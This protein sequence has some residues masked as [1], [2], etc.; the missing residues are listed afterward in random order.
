V[1]FPS[2][3]RPIPRTP[4][5][6]TP[7]IPVGKRVFV[8]CPDNRSGFV[9]LTDE[10]GKVP[11]A[12]HL[13][14]GVEVEVIAWRPRVAGAAHYRVRV[15][16]DGADGWL[17]VA[18]LRSALVPLPVPDSPA[19][20]PTP[21]THAVGKPF[22]PRHRAAVPRAVTTAPRTSV[23]AGG[24][25]FGQHFEAESPSAPPAP[26]SPEPAGDGARRRFGQ[27]S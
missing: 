8:H 3:S 20:Q 5:R 2:R 26:T 18:N 22:E 1:L 23:P 15:P 14:D 6:S 21:P 19:P 24:R 11:S 25:R 4:S 9:T 16:P 10:G 17:P 13:A 12:V 27:H 7:V